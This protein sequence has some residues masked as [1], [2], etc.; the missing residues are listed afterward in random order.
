[1][2][3]RGKAQTKKPWRL[4][5]GVGEICTCITVEKK[6]YGKPNRK[7]STANNQNQN[8]NQNQ[9][10]EE[11]VDLVKV[12]RDAIIIDASVVSVSRCWWQAHMCKKEGG[13]TSHPAYLGLQ[14]TKVTGRLCT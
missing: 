10:D 13:P 9:K 7:C 4:G 12:Q 6:K 2:N 1:M 8:Q 11:R 5:E 3:C 14:A